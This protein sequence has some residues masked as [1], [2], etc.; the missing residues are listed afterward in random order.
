M[1]K[2]LIILIPILLAGCGALRQPA[3]SDVASVSGGIR[4][5]SYQFNSCKGNASEGKV[6]VI[7][8]YSHILAP[9]EISMVAGNNAYAVD[10]YGN[11]YPVSQITGQYKQTQPGYTPVKQTFSNQKKRKTITILK[12]YLTLRYI[13][14]IFY[15]L[16]GKLPVSNR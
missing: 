12:N 16:F 5:F 1:K 8:T 2:L 15:T 6:Y 10:R 13:K 7:F 14:E 4:G 9:Q 11:R 3:V